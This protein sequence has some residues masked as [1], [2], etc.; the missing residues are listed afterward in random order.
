L[1]YRRQYN[2]CKKSLLSSW[3]INP[4]VLGEML[5]DKD[6]E[7]STGVMHAMLQMEKSKLEN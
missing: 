2:L 5:N 6:P 1:T 4:T 3:Q 7:K